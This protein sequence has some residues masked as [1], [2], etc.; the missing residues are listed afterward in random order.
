MHQP[1]Q[2]TF[3]SMGICYQDDTMWSKLSASEILRIFGHLVGVQNTRAESEWL[4]DKLEMEH[5][6]RSF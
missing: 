1:Y 6:S 3:S 5:V 4:F 2:H